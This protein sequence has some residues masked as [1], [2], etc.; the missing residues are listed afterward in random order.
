[1]GY[2]SPLGRSLV[3]ACVLAVPSGAAELVMVE[4]P[5]CHY[6]ERWHAEIGPAWPRTAAARFAPM[7]H[8]QLRDIPDDLDL[9]RRA[10]FTPTFI[11]VDDDG[12]EL[13][14]LEGYPGADFFWP[15]I[16]AMLADHAG[17]DPDRPVNEGGEEG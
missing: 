12:T 16:E 1:M 9:A 15:M 8:V 3:V 14:R 6:C 5:G 11:L 10:S 13:A 17:F 7:R 2:L 4:Q